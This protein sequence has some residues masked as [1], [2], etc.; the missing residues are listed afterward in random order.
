M[1]RRRQGGAGASPS[2]EYRE[3]GTLEVVKAKR[4]VRLASAPALFLLAAIA[5]VAGSSPGVAQERHLTL[6]GGTSQVRVQPGST[7]TVSTS[8]AFADLVVGDP[9][10]A[11]VIP[12]SPY[13]FYV[14]GRAAGTT[15]VSIYDKDQRLLGV[16]DA[17]VAADL[18][19]L[20]AS[21][22]AAVP[23][24]QVIA[25]SV[26]GR[27]RLSGAVASA[28]D[29][30][31]AMEVAG[32]FTDDP[33]INAL[34]VKGAQQVSLEVR[35]IEASRQAGRD[36][37][38]N[39]RAQ[40]GTFLGVTG[41]RLRVNADEAGQPATYLD[42]DRSRVSQGV[43]FGTLV[44]Q[45]LESAGVRV[46][47]IIDALEKKGL[48]RRLAQPNLITVSGEEASFHVGGEVPI[49]AAVTSANGSSATQTD[50]RPYGVRLEFVPTVL[51][52]GLVNLRI[53]TEVSEVDPS[54]NVNGNPGF[55]SRKAQTVLE[56][57]DGQSFA[58][59]GLLQTVN[60]R[61][62]E[63]LPWIGQLPV[64]GT[65]FRSTSFQKRQTDL[66]IVVTPHLVRPARAEEPLATPLDGTRPSN[67]LEL[68]ALGVLEVD[69]NM[70]RAY[71][72]GTGVIGPYGHIID[73]Q[74]GSDA[75]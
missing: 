51:D 33:V 31:R 43:P 71:Q 8:E 66:V 14:Q 44:A 18:G 7:V 75:R 59:A 30:A 28:P 56:L 60:S 20:Q 52:G 9:G 67:D 72:D 5:C 49:Q 48:A 23:G 2:V 53:M 34:S 16:V 3:D 10:I 62:I 35:I 45:V 70:L 4:N 21:I 57:H 65:L 26:N 64:L 73:L 42:Q 32:Q 36:L 55:T 1:H 12:L 47:V 69:E 61:T 19:E 46:D 50:Y 39:V 6:N 54:V 40:G 15:N 74:P 38:V 27:I 13:S 11:D 63:Q 37:G 68:F 58:M 24:S 22:A 29:V 41:A 25:S 17:T